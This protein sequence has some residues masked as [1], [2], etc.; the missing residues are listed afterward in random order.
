[1]LNARVCCRYVRQLLVSNAAA[2][3]AHEAG[4]AAAAQEVGDARKQ[5]K[6][7]REL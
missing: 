2:L 1:M 4:A 3:A 6:G 5:V 7:E